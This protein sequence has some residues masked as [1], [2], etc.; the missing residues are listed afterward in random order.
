MNAGHIPPRLLK[1]TSPDVVLLKAQGMALRVTDDVVLQSISVG[2]RPGDVLVLCTDGVTEAINSQGEEFGEPR[3]LSVITENRTLAAAEI[4][5][6]NLAVIGNFAGDH[7][8]QD[9]ITLMVLRV[10]WKRITVSSPGI[11]SRDFLSG[12]FLAL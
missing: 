7:P 3:L 1:G 2:L 6:T 10:L 5:E 8:Q 9:D 12:V 4:P 11:I